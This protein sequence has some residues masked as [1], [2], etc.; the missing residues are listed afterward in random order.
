MRETLLLAG[1]L[2][3]GPAALAAQS[4]PIVGS[5]RGTSSCLDLVKYP[6]CKNEEVIYDVAARAGTTDTVD[7]KADKVVDGV[8]EF[9]GEFQFVRRA[10]GEWVAE[11]Q[12]AR[13]HG[14]WILMVLGDQMSGGLQ[15]VPTGTMVR[16]VSLKRV[17]S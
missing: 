15:D 5:W 9:M 7:L 4:A 13:Y 10:K 16:R 14:M 6:A 11:F 17:T 3:A 2:V 12:N 1:F 8:R